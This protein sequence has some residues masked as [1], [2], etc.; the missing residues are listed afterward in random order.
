VTVLGDEVN[1]LIV[2]GG[3][4]VAVTVVCVV[5]EAPQAL[6]TVSVYVVVDCG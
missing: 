3:H 5:E 2:G 4:E 6:V 1:V